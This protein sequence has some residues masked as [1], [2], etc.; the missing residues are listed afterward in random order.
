MKVLYIGQFSEGTT[1]EMR[2]HT[3]QNILEPKI[4]DIIDIHIP[5]YNTNKVW[6][7]IG[8]RFKKG[9]LI[10]TIN[11]YIKK[12]FKKIKY[13]LIWVD[14]AVFISEKTTKY[15]RAHAIKLV[16]FTPDMTFLENQSSLFE[17]SLSLYDFV[18]TTKT[19][20]L[21]YYLDK[22]S[23]DKLII[24]TQGF[25]KINHQPM[26][27]FFKKDDSVAFIGL[28][29]PSRFKIMEALLDAGIK[30]K[31]AGFGWDKFVQKHKKN[32]LFIF[33]DEKLMNEDYTQFISNSIIAWGALSKR[34][35]EQHTTRTFEI[36]ACGTA[37]LTENNEEIAS[38]YK[39][40]EVLFYNSTN[41]LIEKV[42]YYSKHKNELELLTQKGYKR[43]HKDGY[44]YESIL[45]TILNKVLK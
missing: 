1:S 23:N 30:I 40:D 43:V 22:I 36:P 2:A 32:P 34:F 16:H 9:P 12:N 17:N 13:D 21:R 14:K 15:L 37:L 24:A 38:F 11:K 33:I 45:R 28:A 8:F 3:I 39:S 19:A 7:S 35:P 44:D 26:V 31:I 25:S 41:E 6:R 42:Q 27:E 20:E 10:F 5:F 29:E 18:I 4:F